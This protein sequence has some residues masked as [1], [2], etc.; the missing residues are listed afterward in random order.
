VDLVSSLAMITTGVSFNDACIDGKALALDETRVHA[1]PHHRLE[2]LA[3][4]VAVAEPAVAIDRE[5]RVVGDL[6]IKIE[7]SRSRRQNQR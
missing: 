3:Q 1:R 2:Y 4:E 5:S 7:S 6:V